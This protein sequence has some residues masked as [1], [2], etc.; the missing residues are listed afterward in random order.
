MKAQLQTLIFGVTVCMVLLAPI[1]AG[2]AQ[3]TT[4]GNETVSFEPLV[5]EYA[6]NNTIENVF[7]IEREN[8]YSGIEELRL[9][10]E[11][12]LQAPN[13]TIIRNESVSKTINKYS[14]AGTGKVRFEN[15]GEHKLTASIE[16][17][18]QPILLEWDVNSPCQKPAVNNSNTST[19]TSDNQ[20]HI[21]DTAEESTTN[22]TNTDN[23]TREDAEDEETS[24]EER[25]HSDEDNETGRVEENTT[26]L[27]TD[28]VLYRPGE[29][30]NIS[31]YIHPIEEDLEITYWIENLDGEIVKNKHT[32]TN[33]YEKHHTFSTIE[34]SEKGY[35]VKAKM[36]NGGKNTSQTKHVM[37]KGESKEKEKEETSL[38]ISS[39]EIDTKSSQAVMTA[40][41]KA[42][43]GETRAEVITIEAVDEDKDPVSE[44]TK[45]KMRTRQ[46]ALTAEIPLSIKQVE[47]TSEIMI[48]AE[49]LGLKEVEKVTVFIPEPKQGKEKEQETGRDEN[50]AKGPEIIKTY[51][52]QKYLGKTLNWYVRVRSEG[53]TRI[54]ARTDEETVETSKKIEGEETVMLTLQQPQEEMKIETK[55]ESQGEAV[56]HSEEITLQ[57][58]EKSENKK[59]VEKITGQS[60]RELTDA[61]LMIE[62]SSKKGP[63]ERNQSISGESSTT[64]VKT[65]TVLAILIP[66][67]IA[68]ILIVKKASKQRKCKT[69]GAK[70]TSE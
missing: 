61:S 67:I 37:V 19:N 64:T 32:T 48:V 1:A 7:H 3:T 59:N 23:T 46:S 65:I 36:R 18:A 16:T 35:A 12:A 42:H 29:R 69:E 51:T 53:A 40:E 4:I 10:Y 21:N 52:R 57:R 41:V 30:M 50:K 22:H 31:F 9:D 55:A 56:K 11:Q 47:E 43:K 14:E 60:T 58:E 38:E 8:Y 24:P 66:T 27:Y 54:K 17:G 63:Q 28:K 25:E 34:T 13:G 70:K 15:H 39:V 2:E 5:E 44:K 49:G 6:C 33:L 26:K 45:L 20:T 62:S 68:T